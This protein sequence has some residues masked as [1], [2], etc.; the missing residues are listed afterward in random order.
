MELQ[1]T[2]HSAWL[3][4]MSCRSLLAYCRPRHTERYATYLIPGSSPYAVLGRN[5]EAEVFGE[6]FG[7]TEE[8]LQREYGPYD[9]HSLFLTVVDQREQQPAG[10]LRVIRADRYGALKTLVDCR[11]ILGIHPSRVQADYAIS[12][13]SAVWDVGT[14]A[15]RAAYRKTTVSGLLYALLHQQCLANG[16]EHVVTVLDASVLALMHG[17]GIPFRPLCG[18]EPFPYMGSAKSVACHMRT[19]DAGPGVLQTLGADNP[20]ARLL[21][22]GE[23]LPE[24]VCLP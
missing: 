8:A 13:P 16:A 19:A 1:S 17:L 6:R 24:L 10:V 9:R 7:D 12:S 18:S 4:D 3:A 21:V 23:G 14:L 11:R 2:D 20:L 22:L 5:L 15:V